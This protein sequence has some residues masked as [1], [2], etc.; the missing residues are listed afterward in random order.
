MNKKVPAMTNAPIAPPYQLSSTRHGAML[1]NSNDVYMG[2][3][4]LRYGECCEIEIRL[5]LSL[6]KVPGM[7]IEVGA[8]MG[9]HTVPMAT[10]LARQGRSMLALEPQPVIFQQLCANL[11]INGLLNVS[12]LSY[13]CGKE[14]GVVS[15]EVPDYRSLGNFGG[16]SMCARPTTPT[17][18]ETVPCIRL[19]DLVPTAA[20]G[21]IKIDVEGYELQVLE[22]SSNIIARSHPVLYVE[23][24]RVNNSPQLIQWLFDHNYQ[25]W[26][27]LPP[28]FNPENFFA[29]KENIYPNIHSSNMLCIPERSNLFIEGLKRV[30]DP[31]FHPFAPQPPRDPQR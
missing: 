29:V 23:N 9:V 14:S 17:R 6:L 12:A 16:T 25:L 1:A 19:D 30:V 22:G 26:W 4:F 21:L 2:Q 24:D 11:A 15:F 5:L 31:Y 3:A 13:A 10:E 27:H 28:L 8:N 20:V 18:H 7:V